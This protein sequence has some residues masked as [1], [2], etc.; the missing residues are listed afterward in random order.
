M[1]VRERAKWSPLASDTR[2]RLEQQMDS[3]HPATMLGRTARSE[4]SQRGSYLGS[5]EVRGG[6]L[7]EGSLS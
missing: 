4:S 2:G 6:F 3:H 5:G 7:E 1:G